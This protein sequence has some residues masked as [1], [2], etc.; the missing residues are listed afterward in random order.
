MNH[1]MKVGAA[2][3]AVLLS[4]PALAYKTLKRLNDW[5]PPGLI[6]GESGVVTITYLSKFT[7]TGTTTAP[8]AAQAS[9][10]TAQVAQVFMA[11]TDTEAIVVHNWGGALGPSFASFGW[12]FTN[13]VKILGAG[14]VAAG[15]SLATNFTFGLTNSNQVYIEKA[16]GAPGGTFLFYMFL[17]SSYMAKQ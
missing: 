6:P 5:T 3:W 1:V 2:L 10:L 8:T 12:P 7:Q 17:P 9:Q 13:L 14:T 16:V 4:L 11:D 15:G